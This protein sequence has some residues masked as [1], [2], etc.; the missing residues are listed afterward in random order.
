MSEGITR[1]LLIRLLN[2]RINE[3]IDI[4]TG[5]KTASNVTAQVQVIDDEIDYL[6]SL[7]RQLEES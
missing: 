3:R 7:L 6:R 1:E 4:L 5:Y 2:R